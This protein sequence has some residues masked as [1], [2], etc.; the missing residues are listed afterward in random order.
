MADKKYD[1]AEVLSD[2]SGLPKK[3]VNS[4]WDNVRKNH[5]L[6]EECVGPHEFLREGDRPPRQFRCTKCNGVIN[7]S[8]MYWYLQG[9][10]HG[11]ADP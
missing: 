4:I 2:A 7:G 10:K 9:L 3:E 11:R 6:L 1:G 8:S 5:K